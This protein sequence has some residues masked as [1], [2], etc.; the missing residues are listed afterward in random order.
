MSSTPPPAL[1][2]FRILWGSML[3][4]IGLYAFILGSGLAQTAA[5][6]QAP[7]LVYVLGVAALMCAGGSIVVPR[8]VYQQAVLKNSPLAIVDEPAPDA[9]SA[10]YRQQAPTRKVFADPAAARQVAMRCFASPFILSIAL[11][12]AVA[13]FGLVLGILGFGFPTAGLFFAGGLCLVAARFPT[14]QRIFEP[15]Q[16]LLG[17][18]IEKS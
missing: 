5:A 14:E 4:S 17:A 18:T 9:S 6:P 8:I 15:F 1:S 2:T 13:L 10:K 16:R 12:E 3:A 11:S 7:H